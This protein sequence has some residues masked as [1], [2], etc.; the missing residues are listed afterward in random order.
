MLEPV[1]QEL[2][3]SL[4]KAARSVPDTDRV[5]F[6]VTRQLGKRSADVSHPGLSNQTIDAYAGDLGVLE[7]AGLINIGHRS[8][9][10]TFG[11]DISPAGFRHIE[12]PTSSGNPEP[13]APRQWGKWVGTSI[14]PF[15]TSR[16]SALWRVRDRAEPRA[17]DCA[18]KE[19]RY[20]KARGSAA[21]SRFIREITTLSELKDQHPGIVQVVDYTVPAEDDN[22][23]PYYVM[24]LAESALDR[25]KAMK[26]HL[27]HVLQIG[28][29]VADALV[30]AHA[31]GIVH[32]DVKPA[33]ILLFG[34]EL[35]PVVCD[36][37]ICFLQEQDRLTRAEADTVGTDDF[38][39]PELLGGGQSD[40]VTPAADVYSL[41][42]TIFAVVQGGNVFPRERF[43]DPRFDLAAQFN[44][45]RLG[46]LRGL[47]EVMVTEDPSQ[48]LQ[49]MAHARE[50][51][52]R[53]LENVRTGVSYQPGLYRGKHSPVERLAGIRR[54]FEA[55]PS[56][57]RN[58]AIQR[59]L[60]GAIDASN[61]CA[62]EYE[63][64]N[65]GS[66]RLYNNRK[67][68][69]AAGV[70]ASCAEHL[71]SAGLPLV[72][73][74][75]RDEFEEWLMLT[76]E[77]VFRADGYQHAVNRLVLAPSGVL[78]A[79]AAGALAW[80]RRRLDLFRLVVDQ[81]L[82]AP[83]R[84][85]H[86][87]ILGGNTT[88][89]HPWLA[90]A[91]TSSPTFQ[92]ADTALAAQ[93]GP[94]LS[95]VSGMAVL[96][97]LQTA[98]AERMGAFLAAPTEPDFPIPFAPGLLDFGWTA[99]LLEVGTVRPPLERDLAKLVFDMSVPEFRALCKRLTVPLAAT[100]HEACARVGMF[101]DL[102]MAVDR[103]RWADW[104]GG[105]F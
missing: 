8:G 104:C 71:M 60:S 89:L 66:L 46:H 1:Q 45:A 82:R 2:L 88:A 39:A 54:L 52:Q 31:V 3:A 22:S 56:T 37:G 34:D 75:A 90:T 63:T 97:F 20:E 11:F 69:E 50:V 81:Y 83:S 35:K 65:Q 72:E 16:M 102:Q 6:M 12:N 17:P 14:K 28:I 93:P 10:T 84:W 32:R 43:D 64:R 73:K 59:E 26:G 19:M 41:G 9:P 78:A 38:V 94:A 18:L 99:E 4:V 62:M 36:F 103:K 87:E 40:K 51:L 5:P 47:M 24:P 76:V 98:D 13:L 15:T 74:D 91:L 33:N 80:K 79:Y 61:A 48:R 100:L 49:T 86:H 96:K 23:R 85:I 58:D 68:D 57:D 44:D 70:A 27:E 29:E 92:R 101:K 55:G 53:A 21:Y 25:A 77:P 30:A 7:K 42:K 105:Q 95:F 67:S